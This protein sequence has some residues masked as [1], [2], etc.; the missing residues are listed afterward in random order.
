MPVTQLMLRASSSDP[1]PETT[2]TQPQRAHRYAQGDGLTF[3]SRCQA[4]Q[5]AGEERDLADVRR[6]EQAGHEPFE[7][8]REPAVRW[9]PRPSHDT[10][11]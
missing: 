10:A 8:E 1:T 6:V 4:V 3:A 7:A 11:I 9:P 5:V 2:G